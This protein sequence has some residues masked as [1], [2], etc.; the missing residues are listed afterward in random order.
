[1][2]GQPFS[3]HFRSRY[4]EQFREY[5][6]MERYSGEIDNATLTVKAENEVCGDVAQLQISNDGKIVIKVLG[7]PPSVAAINLLAEIIEKKELDLK[8][9][10][11]DKI[12]AMLGGLPSTKKHAAHL[13]C[14]LLRRYLKHPH[15]PETR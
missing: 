1:M 13:A 12:V 2:H 7:C 8:K 15:S 3:D 4:S 6:E 9:M 10:D 14:D 5:F 11:A